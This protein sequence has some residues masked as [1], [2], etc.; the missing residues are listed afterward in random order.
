MRNI[1]SVSVVVLGLGLLLP[2]CSAQAACHIAQ[3]DAQLCQSGAAAAIAYQR[4][5]ALTQRAEADPSE[6]SALTALL[7]RSGCQQAGAKGQHG[8]VE[9]IARGPLSVDGKPA[10]VVSIRL[11]HS[12]FWYI[13]AQ[14][15]QGACVKA[16]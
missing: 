9:E 10:E 3:A 2:L 6:Q 1:H 8:S 7:Q 11:D 12:A 4:I 14:S 13:A 15:L 16:D 5:Q